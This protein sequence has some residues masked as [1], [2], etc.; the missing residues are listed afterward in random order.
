LRTY[1]IAFQRAAFAALFIAPIGAF[2]SQEMKEE[3]LKAEIVPNC[4]LAVGEWGTDMVQVCVDREVAALEAV[5]QY[6]TQARPSV[7]RCTERWKRSGWVEVK[8]CVEHDIEARAALAAYASKHHALL[9]QCQAKVG[10]QG[11]AAVKDC[12]DEALAAV[13]A[14]P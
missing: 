13:P 9:E 3:D 11:P 10:A 1:F 4:I 6:R 2:P 5:L 12:V 8:A 14:K 7:A